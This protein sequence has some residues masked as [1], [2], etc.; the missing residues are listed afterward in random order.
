M[1][2]FLLIVF[3]LISHKHTY[4]VTVDDKDL[5]ALHSLEGERER[6]RRDQVVAVESVVYWY[7]I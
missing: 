1:R 3:L 6:E 4:D 2:V 5:V 7:S